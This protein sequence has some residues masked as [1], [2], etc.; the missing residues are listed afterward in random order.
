MLSNVQ[1][2]QPRKSSESF[3]NEIVK[4]LRKVQNWGKT[5]IMKNEYNDKDCKFNVKVVLEF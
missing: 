1:Q 5:I 3:A 2:A 4:K